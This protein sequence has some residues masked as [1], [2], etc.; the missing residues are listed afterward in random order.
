[1]DTLYKAVYGAEFEDQIK[2]CGTNK[3]YIKDVVHRMDYA[4][5]YYTKHYKILRNDPP[6]MGIPGEFNR[7]LQDQ[8]NRDTAQGPGPQSIQTKILLHV[9]AQWDKEQEEIRRIEREKQEYEQS[10]IREA[11][12]R[13]E[14][15]KA[16]IEQQKARA[17]AQVEKEEFD[18]L[19]KAKMVEMLKHSV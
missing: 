18:R 14:E 5:H 10:I 8:V 7:L 13:I 1:M 4:A 6:I 15:E 17:K 2:E 3:D 16:H 12:R 11:T 9:G 19:V